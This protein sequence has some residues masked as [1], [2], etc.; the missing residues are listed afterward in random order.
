MEPQETR[1]SPERRAG[2]A[3]PGTTE[4][5][6]SVTRRPARARLWQGKPPT[7]RTIRRYSLLCPYTRPPAPETGAW[8]GTS[9]EEEGRHPLAFNNTRRGFRGERRWGEHR[10]WEENQKQNR[11]AERLKILITSMKRTRLRQV[12]KTTPAVQ[13]LTSTNNGNSLTWSDS[14]ESA[15]SF[16]KSL[17]CKKKTKHQQLIVLHVPRIMAY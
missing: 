6:G 3:G 17:V 4:P 1:V 13:R 5:P 14:S 8:S 12:C 9:G 7:P 2:R 11:T 15:C 10:E 16:S